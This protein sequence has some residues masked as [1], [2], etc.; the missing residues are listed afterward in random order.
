ME[1]SKINRVSEFLGNQ[2]VNLILRLFIGLI[3][4]ISAA[5]KLPHHV[6]FEAV[7]KEYEILPD[8]LAAAYANAL[9]WVELTPGAAM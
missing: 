9:P 1:Q 5:S 7:V 3:F 6:E 4:I 2:Y 8:A